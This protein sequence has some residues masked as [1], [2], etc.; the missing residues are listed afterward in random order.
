MSATSEQPAKKK[1]SEVG[2][3]RLEQLL[4]DYLPQRLA[5]E[6]VEMLELTINAACAEGKVEGVKELEKKL[7]GETR[8]S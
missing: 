7:F 4:N 8:G 6:A 2:R 5:D 1:A 3:M